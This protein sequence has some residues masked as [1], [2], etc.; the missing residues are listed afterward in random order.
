MKVEAVIFDVDGTLWNTTDLVAKG[1][2]RGIAEVGVER[3]AITGADLR[4][5]FGKPMN[6][7]MDSLFAKEDE[8]TK[9]KL[10]EVCCKYEQAVLD[11]LEDDILYPGV[12]EVF[13]TLSKKC[14][15]AIVSNC[16]SGYIEL[17]MRKNGFESYV[18]DKECYGDTLLSKGENIKMLMERNG[19]KDAI[20]V[21]DTMGDYKAATQAGLPFVFVTYGFGEVDAPC[22]KIDDIRG[23]LEFV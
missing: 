13:E 20:Y 10:L 1:W 17:F 23:V 12:R 3:E 18:L 6:A 7:I 15:I 16:H 4:R 21:G 8:E 9:A 19:I 14:K 11:E 2:N 22:K 5:E